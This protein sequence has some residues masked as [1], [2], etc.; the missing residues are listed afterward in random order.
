MAASWRKRLPKNRLQSWSRKKYLTNIWKW[1]EY[2]AV[3]VSKRI[4]KFL[5]FCPQTGGFRGSQKLVLNFMN[6]EARA[7]ILEGAV[8][9]ARIAAVLAGFLSILAFYSPKILAQELL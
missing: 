8:R 6:S 3:W 5:L 1:D 9:Q 4:L 2:G 7:S